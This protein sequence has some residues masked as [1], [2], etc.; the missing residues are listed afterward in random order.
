MCQLKRNIAIGTL[1]CIIEIVMVLIGGAQAWLKL[2]Q[3]GKFRAAAIVC[4]VF[5]WDVEIESD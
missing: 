5:F 2:W 1:D 3:L 4:G